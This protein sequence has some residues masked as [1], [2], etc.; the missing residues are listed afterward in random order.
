MRTI[1]LIARKAFE[2]S[3]FTHLQFREPTGI[4]DEGLTPNE[5]DSFF[6]QIA[7][8]RKRGKIYIQKDS[9][10]RLL[11]V[12]G[13]KEGKLGTEQASYFSSFISKI[14]ANMLAVPSGI[15]DKFDYV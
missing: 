5:L 12:G 8:I 3:D 7:D 1:A 13:R 4:L 15:R 2:Q 9:R 11:G 10:R 6:P 14:P